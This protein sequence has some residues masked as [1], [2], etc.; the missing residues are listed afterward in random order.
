VLVAARGRRHRA[1]YGGPCGRRPAGCSR[2][3]GRWWSTRRQRLPAGRLTVRRDE[4]GAGERAGAGQRRAWVELPGAGV[5]PG[6]RQ[7]GPPTARR[8]AGAR[9][10]GATRRVSLWTQRRAR[11]GRRGEDAGTTWWT[12]SPRARGPT[13]QRRPRL[14]VGATATRAPRAR[15][16]A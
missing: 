4:S 10:A 3:R 14:V 9:R 2:R 16:R 12:D 13:S 6:S 15:A 1:A 5:L 11:R 7:N 8:T